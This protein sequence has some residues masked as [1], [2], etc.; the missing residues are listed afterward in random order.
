[1]HKPYPSSI[2]GVNEMIVSLLLYVSSNPLRAK[3]IERFRYLR[4]YKEKHY[5]ELLR[6][7]HF[8]MEW[9]DEAKHECRAL[10]SA[11]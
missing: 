5:D 8:S 3:L 10:H 2:K 9:F 1:M 6:S 4:G 7:A 11:A